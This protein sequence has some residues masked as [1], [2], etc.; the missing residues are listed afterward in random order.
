MLIFNVFNRFL[1]AFLY[2]NELRVIK[3]IKTMNQ[4]H[5]QWIRKVAILVDLGVIPNDRSSIK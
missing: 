2:V 5:K 3:E 1:P 4:S